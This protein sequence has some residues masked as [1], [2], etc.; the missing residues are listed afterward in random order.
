[1]ADEKK[2]N[3]QPEPTPPPRP[4]K[5]LPDGL[6]DHVEKMQRP[7]PWADPPEDKSDGK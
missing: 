2:P 3:P 1:M 4:K 7:I 5:P 6:E